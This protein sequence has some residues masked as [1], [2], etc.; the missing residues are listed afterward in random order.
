MLALSPW[1]DETNT[2][3]HVPS[4]GYCLHA[5]LVVRVVS[6]SKGAQTGANS[7]GL[8]LYLKGPG[9]KQMPKG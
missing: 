9:I 6:S 3:G 2:G 7:V 5:P 4:P 1:Q 8:A